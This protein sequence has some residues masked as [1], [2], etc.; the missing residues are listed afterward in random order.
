MRHFIPE[1]V[2]IERSERDTPLARTVIERVKGCPIHVVDDVRAAEPGDFVAGKRRLVLQRHRGSFLRHCP[3][4]TAG[5]VCCNYLVVS[6]AS[7]CPLDCSYCFLQDY[8]RNNPALKAFTN[9]GDALA[10][11]ASVLDAHPQ[12][13]F[14]IGTGELA[15]SL[16][17]DPAT[18]LSRLLV[19]FFAERANAVL[20]LKTKT[21]CVDELL[22]LQPNG[23]VVVSWSVN[24]EQIIAAEEPGTASLAQRLAAA[25]R[26]QCAAYRV[27]FH[28]DPLI[29]FDGWEDGYR[30]A[31][32]AIFAA[33]DPAS[34]A[35]VSLGSLRM[36]PSLRQV[37]RARGVGR[38][39]LGAELVPNGDGKSRVWRGLR[40]RMYRFMIEQLNATAPGVA[41]Y[42]CMEPPA[43]WERVRRVVPTD[44]ALGMHLASGAAW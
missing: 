4:G 27:G 25:R 14:R 16:A 20:E 30:E 11:I 21:D 7:N 24:A 29:E 44:R 15:D 37:I 1:E 40:L 17:L 10:E 3:A 22:D 26:V 18:G 33:V 23:H 19:P 43:V 35:W 12:R 31:V 2:W 5:M 28:F 38:H 13:T 39:V 32:R 6:L 42:L 36:T 8:V 9:V 34:V 41:Y